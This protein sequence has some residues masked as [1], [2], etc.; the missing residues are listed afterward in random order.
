[1]SIGCS[2][3][4]ETAINYCWP[5]QI[6]LYSVKIVEVEASS[7][8]W[9]WMPKPAGGGSNSRLL[10][11]RWSLIQVD[12]PGRCFSFLVAGAV[13]ICRWSRSWLFL[14]EAVVTPSPSDF[15]RQL[16]PRYPPTKSACNT[17]TSSRCWES[18]TGSDIPIAGLDKQL[19]PALP[20]TP[21]AHRLKL[22]PPPADCTFYS[23]F[24]FWQTPAADT[25][26]P[27]A[28]HSTSSF[29]QTAGARNCQPTANK[30]VPC[31]SQCSLYC[32][33]YR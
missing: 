5:H 12:V 7:R 30:Y 26:Q 29:W 9:S 10:A 4:H 2:T 8:G 19:P 20:P 27:A 25:K 21:S 6:S 3:V 23:T 22:A 16:W 28:A 15:G 14:V 18:T 11:E 32:C 13:T 31:L 24:R 17:E 33:S 1:M